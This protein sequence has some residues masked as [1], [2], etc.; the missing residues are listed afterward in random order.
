MLVQKNSAV[1]SDA[2]NPTMMNGTYEGWQDIAKEAVKY[3]LPAFAMISPFAK[4]VAQILETPA[5]LVHF[6]GYSSIGKTL[7]LQLATSAYA[8]AG[9]PNVGNSAIKKWNTPSVLDNATGMLV[10]DELH[11]AS[12]K[13][14]FNVVT[15]I[16]AN[17]LILSA[18]E[19]SM[20]DKFSKA[21][22]VGTTTG[23]LIRVLDIHLKGQIFT[24]FEGNELLSLEAEKL[25]IKLKELCGLHYGHAGLDFTQQLSNLAYSKAVIQQEVQVML[26]KLVDGMELVPEVRRAIGMF[27]MIAVA[28]NYAVQF[29][30]LPMTEQNVFDALVYVRDLWLSEMK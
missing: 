1:T 22:S 10:L 21:L 12:D 13:A 24:D 11:M 26:E 15:Q 28:G 2:V 25:A 8:N 29:G 4:T 16:Q 23:K 30:I 3:K 5:L 14:F 20:V 17:G 19:Q 6:Y 27:A 9:D 7:L 18:G